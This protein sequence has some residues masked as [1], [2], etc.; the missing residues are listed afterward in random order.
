[1]SAL[2]CE[3]VALWHRYNWE[4]CHQNL[5]TSSENTI[6]LISPKTAE[7]SCARHPI[8]QL[9]GKHTRNYCADTF[10]AQ[11]CSSL[12]FRSDTLHLTLIW[13]NWKIRFFLA[14]CQDRTTQE[15]IK[16][17]LSEQSRTDMKLDVIPPRIDCYQASDSSI[18][19]CKIKATLRNFWRWCLLVLFFLLVNIKLLLDWICYLWVLNTFLGPPYLYPHPHPKKSPVNWSTQTCRLYFQYLLVAV[20]TASA[21][22]SKRY[23]QVLALD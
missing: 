20:L 21:D 11:S 5:C 1:M 7:K 4:T 19:H 15:L 8:M 3:V 23:G 14:I 18:S 9:R 12:Q 6:N 10:W 16:L 22:Y 2:S 13:R 17:P